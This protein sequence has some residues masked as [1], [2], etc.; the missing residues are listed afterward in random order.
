MGCPDPPP[1][2]FTYRRM[3][4]VWPTLL[5]MPEPPEPDF[6]VRFGTRALG[7]EVAHLFGSERDARL[8][9]GSARANEVSPEAR[10]RH[11]EVPLDIRVPV[12]LSRILSQK[13]CKTYPRPTWLVIRNAYPL[14]DRA[15]FEM[16][17]GALAVPDT[18]SFEEIWLFSDRNAASGMIRLFPTLGT[19]PKAID[20]AVRAEQAAR[21]GCPQ[22]RPAQRGSAARR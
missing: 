22:R 5:D 8:L 18:H 4:P 7:V 13:R 6:V 15:D 21:P 2:R 10:L 12:E 3:F 11:A 17:P 1:P 14:W 16:Y 9:L 19:N 20:T